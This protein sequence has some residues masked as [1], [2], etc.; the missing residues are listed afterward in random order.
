MV[1]HATGLGYDVDGP[2]YQEMLETMKE[3]VDKGY[4]IYA[5]KEPVLESERDLQVELVTKTQ[6][7]LKE[8]S[9]NF[10][11]LILDDA[12]MEKNDDVCLKKWKESRHWLQ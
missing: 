3:T 11:Q 2:L 9:E 1:F 5:F 6:F 8:Y 12:K 10:C 7:V 4:K